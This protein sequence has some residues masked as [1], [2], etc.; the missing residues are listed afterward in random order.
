MKIIAE[1]CRQH[2]IRLKFQAKAHIYGYD[3]TVFRNVIARFCAITH[4]GAQSPS[5]DPTLAAQIATI[6]AIG[7]HAHPLLSP[8]AIYEIFR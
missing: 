5:I 3:S 2:E 8:P 7:N 1:H 4:A 6:P